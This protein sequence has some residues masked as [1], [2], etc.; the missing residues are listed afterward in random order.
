M[1][2]PIAPPLKKE[3]EEALSTRFGPTAVLSVDA[4]DCRNSST[5]QRGLWC[6]NVKTST[7]QLTLMLKGSPKHTSLDKQLSYMGLAVPHFFGEVRVGKKKYGIWEFCVGR[8]ERDYKPYGKEDVRRLSREIARINIRGRDVSGVKRGAL[9]AAPV[10]TGIFSL[11]EGAGASPDLFEKLNEFAQYE[12]QLLARLT[13]TSILILNHNDLKA[14]YVIIS[15]QSLWIID[16]ERT[17]LGPPG[18]SLRT[19]AREAEGLELAAVQAYVAET[20]VLGLDLTVED[21]L[22]TM[23]AQQILWG[24][25]SGLK[26]RSISRIAAGLKLF[27]KYLSKKG[28]A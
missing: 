1:N 12:N 7:Q 26:V 24:L 6:V 15:D 25:S 13:D 3:L 27:R 18:A 2:A 5:P 21:V 19:F 23:R 17:S 10:A 9:W 16:W 11:F 28:I 20:E 14:P 22:V 4:I 8:T